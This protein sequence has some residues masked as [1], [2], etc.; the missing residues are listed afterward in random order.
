V[1]DGV[2]RF[3]VAADVF[4]LPGPGGLALN[5]AMAYGLPVV[6]AGGD[7][8]EH[9]LVEPGRSGFLVADEPALHEALDALAADGALRQAMA[10]A[11][12][13]R[14]AGFSVERMRRGFVEAL[15]AVGCAGPL[16]PRGALAAP[17][18][19]ARGRA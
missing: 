2:G 11:A 17:A 15:G 9:D 6:A 8:T 3:F 16:E 19:R 12:L 4:A 13:A 5:Q 18:G 1:V 10:G 14:V 7:G